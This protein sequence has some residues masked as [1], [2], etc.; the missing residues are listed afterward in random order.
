MFDGREIISSF[1]C[2]KC[3]YVCCRVICFTGLC[4][5]IEESE[6]I[7]E[8][9]KKSLKHVKAISMSGKVILTTW[10]KVKLIC[11]LLQPDVEN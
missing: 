3:C 10:G 11:G 7:F 6:R 9:I 8:L 4:S 2:I 1:P 5:Q